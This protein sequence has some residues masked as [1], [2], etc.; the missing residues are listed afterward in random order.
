MDSG[1][2]GGG[3][4]QCQ[5]CDEGSVFILLLSSVQTRNYPHHKWLKGVSGGGMDGVGSVRCVMR[6]DTDTV[7]LLS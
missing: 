3:R 7:H 5:M 4:G 6:E 1:R 2:E